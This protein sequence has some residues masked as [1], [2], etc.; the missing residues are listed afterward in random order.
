MGWKRTHRNLVELIVLHDGGIFHTLQCVLSW[1]G[2][3]E[4]DKL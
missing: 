4:D 3:N 1:V 2:D